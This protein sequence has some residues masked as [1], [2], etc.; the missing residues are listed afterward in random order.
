M[1]TL[2]KQLEADSFFITDLK[3]CRV[4]L[5]NNANFPWLILV[6]KIEEAVELTDL[7]FFVQID[8]LSEINLVAKIVQ[9]KFSPHKLNIANLGNIVRQLHI[10]VVGRFE[11]DRAFP[12]PVWGFEVVKYDEKVARDLVEEIREKIKTVA[13]N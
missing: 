2:N 1:F 7:P 5:M 10:H 11:A 6:P 12:K 3:I 8:I 4:L 9:K 13:K